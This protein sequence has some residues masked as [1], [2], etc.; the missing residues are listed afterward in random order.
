MESGLIL[1]CEKC[2]KKLGAAEGSNPAVEFKD[3]MKEDIAAEL[4]KSVVRAITT[5]CMKVCPDGKITIAIA[6][7]APAKLEFFTVDPEDLGKVG[8]SLVDA[9]KK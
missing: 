5:S 1:I 8:V 2:G 4:G 3:Q 9:F 6:R 7:T